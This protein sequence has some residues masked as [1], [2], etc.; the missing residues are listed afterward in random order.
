MEGLAKM[1]RN[2][3]AGCEAVAELQLKRLVPQFGYRLMSFYYFE[4]SLRKILNVFLICE[5]ALQ[6]IHAGFR[7]IL[8]A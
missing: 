1:L 3:F 8:S 4:A 6:V 2:Y 7:C 5:A